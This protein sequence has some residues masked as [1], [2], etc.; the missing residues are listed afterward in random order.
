MTQYQKKF[1]L[2][3]MIFWTFLFGVIAA[4]AAWLGDMTGAYH[5]GWM[6]AVIISLAGGYFPGLLGGIWRLFREQNT[7]TKYM[8]IK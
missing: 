3:R 2:K 6:T 4:G 1:L 8:V 7:E 5:S